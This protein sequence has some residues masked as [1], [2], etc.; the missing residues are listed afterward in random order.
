MAGNVNSNQSDTPMNQTPNN[1]FLVGANGEMFTA[2]TTPTPTPSPGATAVPAIAAPMF[3]VSGVELA[4]ACCQAG[5]V[6]SLTRNHCRDDAEMVEQLKTVSEALKRFADSNP[7]KVIGPLAMNISPNFS[8]DEFRRHLECCKRHGVR[9]I[10]T[11]V[12]DPTLNAPLVQD[13]GLL[14][15]HDATTIR[16]AE[17]AAAAGV[18]AR[19]GYESRESEGTQT[20]L[21]TLARGLG[22]CRDLAVL[23]VEAARCLRFGA[24]LCSGYLYRPERLESE[25]ESTHAWAEVFVPGAGWITFDPTNRS[26]GGRNLIPVAV[27]REIWQVTPVSGAFTGAGNAYR[28]LW[29]EV[30]Q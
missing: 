1:G 14:H 19:V 7:G 4:I 3:L 30:V 22:S 17:K 20:P 11:S 8:Q 27:A 25:M 18:A 13:A 9:I 28:G 16:V 23:F 29:V 24:R 2:A 5:I 6:G 21:E 15:F 10:V 12:G 26:V